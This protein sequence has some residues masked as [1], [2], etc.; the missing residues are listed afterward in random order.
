MPLLG[1]VLTELR[2]TL[3][4][5]WPDMLP[6]PVPRLSAAVSKRAGDDLRPG[7]SNVS[8]SLETFGIFR[9]GLALSRIPRLETVPGTEAE[10]LGLAD[11]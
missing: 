3:A 7:K 1:T 8:S 11:R 6:L 5:G 4:T 9:E 2:G 10:A